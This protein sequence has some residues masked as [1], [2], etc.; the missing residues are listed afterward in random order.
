MK[1]K[2]ETVEI[3]KSKSGNLVIEKWK[4]RSGKV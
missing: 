2:D 3:N 1:L 4:L